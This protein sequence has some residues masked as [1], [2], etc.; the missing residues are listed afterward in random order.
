MSVDP[1][2]T[3]Y[4]KE[5]PKQPS[6]WLCVQCCY[7]LGINPFEKVKKSKAKAAPQKKEDRAKIVHYDTKKGTLALSE[8]C[9][10]VSDA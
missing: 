9:I 6:T 5:H 3:A 8:I 1:Y 10:N 2:Q 4:T 7:A